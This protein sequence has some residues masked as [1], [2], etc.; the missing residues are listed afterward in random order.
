MLLAV[1]EEIPLRLDYRFGHLQQPF[2]A[3][4]DR[5]NDRASGFKLLLDELMSLGVI[6]RLK[7]EDLG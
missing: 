3:V 7:L 5:V 6:M 2:L 1:V 4:F